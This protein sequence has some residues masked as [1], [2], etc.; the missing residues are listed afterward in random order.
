[1][2]KKNGLSVNDSILDLLNHYWPK[3]KQGKAVEFAAPLENG[4]SRTFIIGWTC[5]NTGRDPRLTS[6]PPTTKL[7]IN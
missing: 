7:E 6:D 2:T 5:D 3:L 1:M 4:G